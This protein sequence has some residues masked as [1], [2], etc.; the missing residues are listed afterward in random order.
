MMLEFS[1]M[2]GAGNDFIVADDRGQKWSRQP[3]F[4]QLICDR[5]RGIG[6]DGF[7]LLSAPSS[8]LADISMSFF[9]CNG[10]PAEMCG[11]GLRCASLFTYNYILKNTILQIQTDTGIL[12]AEVINSQ[13]V[14]IEIPIIKE[15]GKVILENK[16]CYTVN[17]GV[18]H[19]IL[20][21]N[22]IN[23]INIES[24][25]SRFRNHPF[26][27]PEGVNVNFIAIPD[28]RTTIPIRTYER[29]VEGETAACGTGIAA[30]ALT[31]VKIYNFKF[32]INFMT[33]QSETITVDFCGNDNMVAQFNKLLLSGPA[34]EVFTGTLNTETV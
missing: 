13:T 17:T 28:K 25:G 20:L 1:K 9:N 14:K 23:N 22:D 21:C 8:S 31:L 32:P 29:G 24:E 2:H 11:N 15:P 10:K 33:S 27:Q 4:I 16:E 26:F 34:V 12:R 6:A 3:E 30:A 19:L 5:K 18:P 7:I